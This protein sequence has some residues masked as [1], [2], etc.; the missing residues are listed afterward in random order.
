MS[1][2]L[3]RVSCNCASH[4]SLAS[5]RLAA[6]GVYCS[7]LLAHVAYYVGQFA[8]IVSQ[9]LGHR[10]VWQLMANSEDLHSRQ[11]WGRLL[12]PKLDVSFLDICDMWYVSWQH[13]KS[14]VLP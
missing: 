6:L 3:V 8:G 12:S 11:V 13:M 10:S 7:Y 9:V 1:T 2:M 14:C 5:A 4:Y